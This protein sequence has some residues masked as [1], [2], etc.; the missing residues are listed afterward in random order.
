VFDLEVGGILKI[1]LVVGINR[2]ERVS[3]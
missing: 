2:L 3:S 1:E